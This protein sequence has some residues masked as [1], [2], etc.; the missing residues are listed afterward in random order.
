M[1]IVAQFEIQA[2]TGSRW[3]LHSYKNS[4]GQAVQ[5]ARTLLKQRLADEVKVTQKTQDGEKVV[6]NED[7]ESVRKKA[8]IGQIQSS[9]LMNSVDDLYDEPSRRTLVKL[10]RDYFDQ[11]A[12]SPTELL[13]S[14]RALEKLCDS[15]L[16]NSALERLAALQAVSAKES[17]EVRKD[18]L[19]TLFQD[20]QEFARVAPYEDLEPGKLSEYVEEAGGLKDKTARFKIMASL[21]QATLRSPSWEGKFAVLFDL[22]GKQPAK[23]LSE[24]MQMLLD[25]IL[26]EWFLVPIV[27]QE[28]LGQQ[29]DRYNAMDVLTKLCVAKYEARKW[30]TPGLKRI[31]DLMTTLPMSKSRQVLADLVEQML[32]GRSALTRG[33]IHEEKHAFKQLLPLFI[34][35]SG[36]ILGGEGMAE[37]LTMCGTRSFNRDRNLEKPSE[38][39][40]YI[41]ENLGAPILQLRY[42]LTLS[43]SQFGKDC[44][45]IVCEFIPTFM[46]GPEHVHDIVHYRLPL[47]RKLRIITNLQKQALAISL[48]KDMNIRLVE[49]LDEMLYSYLDEERI[50]DKMDSPQD[51]LFKRATALLQF[52]AS[53]LLI[54]GKTLNWVRERVQ[55]HLRQPN[56]VERFTEEVETPKKKEL[57][58]TQLHAMLKKAGLQQ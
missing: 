51:S 50:I 29:P 46:D 58:I 6:F 56:F 49:W 36:T 43:K 8:G 7:Q 13:H 5:E 48:P 40:N 18:H 54:E 35:K 14:H 47:K 28:L 27:I 57:V 44:A 38:A 9:P 26:S 21:S 24:D 52:C 37:A 20:T 10:L 39:I 33:D 4:E 16:F 11:N 55:E 32:R 31:S 53:G 12:L 15:A 34:S 42:L 23:D 30:D 3:S 2:K 45:N 25:D 17:E 41:V 1:K 19:Y 22:V